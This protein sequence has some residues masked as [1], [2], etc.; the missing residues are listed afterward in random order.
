[1]ETFSDMSLVMQVAVFHNKRAFD[2]LVVIYKAL[3]I[4]SPIERSCIT[5]QLTD[6]YKIDKIAEITGRQTR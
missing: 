2:R 1:M 5:L 3:A 4:L 6:G